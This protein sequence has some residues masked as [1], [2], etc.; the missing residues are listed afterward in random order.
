M[1]KTN[2]MYC[3]SRNVCIVEPLEST[4]KRLERTLPKDHEDRIA[5][6]GFNWLGSPQSLCTSLGPCIKQC[7]YRMLKPLWTKSGKNS[8][9]AS[10]ANDQCKEQK[11][12]SF[13]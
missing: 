6:K 12:R 2:P 13:W 7:K 8:K 10:M 4:R 5:G 9:I 11:Q 1:A 3:I